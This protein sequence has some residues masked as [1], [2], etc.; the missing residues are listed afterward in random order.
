M[1]Y[2]FEKESTQAWMSIREE[3]GFIYAAWFEWRTKLNAFG[4]LV[5]N[6]GHLWVGTLRHTLQ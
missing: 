5:S 3:K 1:S 4:F 2:N 6:G